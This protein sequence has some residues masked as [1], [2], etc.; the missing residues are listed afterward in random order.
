MFIG[1]QKDKIVL[2]AATKEA[3]EKMPCMRFDRIEETAQEYVLYDGAYLTKD[4]ADARQAQAEKTAQIKAL[5]AELEQLDL[6]AVRA[7]RALSAGSA[8]ETD[9]AKLA[10]LEQQA[11]RIR[12]QMQELL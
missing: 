5:Q 12:L 7:L 11:A 6:K 1:Y 2:A 4:E 3:L 9:K 10:E 8:S